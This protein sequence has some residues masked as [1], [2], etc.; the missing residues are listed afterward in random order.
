MTKCKR[1][2]T[3]DIHTAI[4]G[5]AH[6]FQ[7]LSSRGKSRLQIPTLRSRVELTDF[8][9]SRREVKADCRYP[10]CDHGWSSDF[11]CSRR[12]PTADIH[13]VITGG[14]HRFQLLSSR[15]KSR[16]QISTLRSRVELTD[17]NCSRRE[18]TADIHTAITG[19]AHRFQLLSSRG[20]GQLP[21]AWHSRIRR[22]SDQS[23]LPHRVLEGVSSA[24]QTPPPSRFCS[25]RTQEKQKFFV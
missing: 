20:K 23:T 12:E 13:T 25:L 7:L 15:G 4:T 1:K 24:L 10:H 6:R 22:A 19:G 8:N 9:C 16:L 3:A 2:P 11:N 5:G 17:F 21:L 14:A 18:P